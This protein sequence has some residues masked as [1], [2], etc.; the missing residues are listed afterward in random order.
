MIF[1]YDSTAFQSCLCRFISLCSTWGCVKLNPQPEVLLLVLLNFSVVPTD[2]MLQEGGQVG[3][4]QRVLGFDP[5]Y[6]LIQEEAVLA[7][8]AA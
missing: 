1:Y 2:K 7:K 5:H 4:R 8:Q 3:A 6:A